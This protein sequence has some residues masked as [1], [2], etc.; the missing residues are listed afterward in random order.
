MLDFDDSCHL[1]LW[2]GG[3]SAPVDLDP[4][5][6]ARIRHDQANDDREPSDSTL[7]RVAGGDLDALAVLYGRY[8]EEVYH[9]AYRLTGS[10]QDAQDVVQDLFVGLPEAIT[11]Y[12]RPKGFGAWLRTVAARTA[13]QKTRERQRRLQVAMDPDWLVGRPPPHGLRLDLEA[14]LAALPETLRAV[15]VLKE[16]EGFSHDEIGDL[17]GITA[18]ASATRLMRAREKLRRALD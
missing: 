3:R 13:I 2:N 1:Y 18:A 4:R 14:A 12:G 11:C 15:V 5:A 6:N 8:A 9:L 7:D 17:L 10:V 16:V